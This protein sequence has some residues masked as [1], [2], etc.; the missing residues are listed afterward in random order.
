MESSPAL[1]FKKW[2]MVVMSR[3]ETVHLP[4]RENRSG[5]AQGKGP[6]RTH[7]K[8]VGT[9]PPEFEVYYFVYMCSPQMSFPM[10]R[11]VQG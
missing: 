2:A 10:F 5:P 8:W 4:D 1:R 11:D 7:Q 3:G 9:H 6:C